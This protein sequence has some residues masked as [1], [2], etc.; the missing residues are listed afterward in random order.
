MK[1]WLDKI[2]RAMLWALPFVVF[3]A[4]YPVIKLGANEQMNFELS[5]PL[6]WL[7]LF[8]G[9]SILR[10]PRI[11]KRF[12]LKQL[13]I[14]GLF[15]ITATL[16]VVWSRNFVRGFLEAGILDLLFVCGLNILSLRPSKA[17][18]AKFAKLHVFGGA[19]ASVICL[20]QCFLDVFG[21]PKNISLLCPG[22]GYQVFGFSHPNG[23]AIEPQFMG[24]LLIAPALLSLY[25]AYNTIVSKSSK[26]QILL[27]IGLSFLNIMALYIC[28]SRGAIYAFILSLILF[29]VLSAKKAKRKNILFLVYFGVSFLGFSTGLLC[30]GVLAEFSTTSESFPQGIARAVHHL[31]LG[32]IDFRQKEAPAPSAEGEAA[33]FDGYIEESTEIRLGLNEAAFKTWSEDADAILNGVGLGGAGVAIHEKF[34]Y[35]SEKEIVQ[36]QFLSILLELGVIGCLSLLV[37]LGV[38]IWSTYRFGANAFFWALLLAYV[39]SLNFFSGLPNVLHIYLL[40]PLWMRLGAHNKYAKIG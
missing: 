21:A 6:I 9:I 26:R 38:I 1:K 16:S 14:L 5:L 24:N 28:F 37:T 34:D 35:Y 10:F 23:L 30:Q 31:S 18:V 4:Y 12:K 36:N 25:F 20:V 11:L 13:W 7:A 22:C 19:I 40:A 32:K 39:V 3:F 29:V 15:P 8:G 33:I 17:E 2:E 27:A